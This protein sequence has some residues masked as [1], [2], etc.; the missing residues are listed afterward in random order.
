MAM[1]ATTSGMG[2]N[3]S[4]RVRL[5]GQLALINAGPAPITVLTATGQRPDARIRY[6]GQPRPIPPGSTALVDVEV[7]FE[8]SIPI[9]QEPLPVRFSIKTGDNRNREVNAPVGLLFSVWY[10]DLLQACGRLG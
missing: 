1:P 5:D 8:C 6:T 2:T 10:R 4:G 3:S 9:E 7:R